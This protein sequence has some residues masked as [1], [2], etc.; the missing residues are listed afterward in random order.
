MKKMLLVLALGLVLV[1]GT[2]FAEHPDGTGIGVVFGGGWSGY[3]Y[4]LY[5]GLSLKLPSMPIYWGIYAHLSSYGFGVSATGDYY[6]I[7]SKLTTIGSGWLGWYLGLG[8]FAGIDFWTGGLALNAGV[9]V[10]LGLSWFINRSA[11]LFLDVAPG[12]GLGIGSGIGLYWAG[13]AEIGL[14]FWL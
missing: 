8:G 9:R 1:T 10:P 2:V 4:N 7:D 6:L 5:P 11:E 3:G 14:R 12:I 13:N